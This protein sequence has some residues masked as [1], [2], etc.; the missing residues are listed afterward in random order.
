[1]YEQRG[2]PLS[3]AGSSVATGI[4]KNLCHWCHSQGVYRTIAF[5]TMIRRGDRYQLEDDRIF[6]SST[7]QMGD[8]IIP[9]VIQHR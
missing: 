2:E 1:M 3:G 9:I 5:V 4:H 8:E 6:V 7:S